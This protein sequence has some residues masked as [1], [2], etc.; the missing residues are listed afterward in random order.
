M[1]TLPPKVK[2]SEESILCAALEITREKGLDSVNAREL[3]KKLNCSTQPIFRTFKNM[4]ELKTKL[5]ARVE[6][7][8]NEY[9][10]NG[11]KNENSFLGMGLAYIEFAKT[12]RNLFK[13]LFMSDFIKVESVFEMIEGD[14]NKEVIAIISKSTGLDEEHSKQLYID[15][16]LVTHGIA[17]MMATNCC[18]FSEKEILQ[19]LKDA[20]M[21]FWGQLKKNAN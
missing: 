1:N 10:L 20:F 11:M 7:N 12:E 17:S 15:I 2:I 21:G 13:L 19:I 18:T 16:W 3:A 14:D 4:D 8:Y 9:M 5:Y 6:I